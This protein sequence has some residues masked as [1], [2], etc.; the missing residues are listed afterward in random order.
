M[1]C[2]EDFRAIARDALRGR[3]LVA[4][5]T[6]FV[7]SLL[8][9]GIANSGSSISD[10]E[11]RSDTIRNLQG[12]ELWLQIRG[13]VF[14]A[15][16]VLALWV[17]VTMIIGGAVKLGYAVFNLKLV[18]QKDVAFSDLFSQSNRLGAGFCM[19]FLTGLYT[20]LWTMLFIVPGIIKTFSYAMTPYILA[21]NPGM[22]ATEA[23]TQSRRI[24]DGNKWRL[25]CLSFSFI[26]WSLLCAVP[27]LIVLGIVSGVAFSTGSLAV[28]LWMIPASIPTFIGTLFLHPYQ[29]A[30]Y[31]AFYRDI[32]ATEVYSA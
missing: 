23:I 12:T 4:V 5:L 30:A 11:S 14:A 26:G 20:L 29:E 16:L 25:F 8:G 3:W 2:A 22:T 18:D 17:I 21:E 24:M 13:F 27:T 6:G 9:A 31:A 32:S 15:I 28:F 10:I 7:A 19:N 1:K